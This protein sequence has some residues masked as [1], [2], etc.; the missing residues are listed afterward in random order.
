MQEETTREQRGPIVTRADI[1]A[2]LKALDLGPGSAA[3]V[4]SSLSAFG[5]VQGG[6]DAVI[7]ALLDTIGA[8][9]TLVMP[10]FTWGE[11]HA[12]KQVTFDT[13]H[14]VCETGRIPET[15]RQR[16]GVTR[17]LHVCHSVAACGP[18][19]DLAMGEGVSSF[20]RGSTFDG[21]L[22]LNAWVVMLGVSFQSCTALHAVEEFV[23]VGYREHRDFTESTVIL[24]DGA[25][26]SS[27][28]IEYLRVDSSANDFA[29]VE[30]LLEEAGVLRQTRI[31]AA[32]SSAVRIHDIFTVV[33]PRLEQDERFLSRSL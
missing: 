10:T 32:T 22:R 30:A 23:G 6:A 1:H 14:T 7:D 27:K 9:G 26:L 29:K 12:R 33:Q 31:G 13:R 21:L 3:M 19:T 4:H 28:A 8:T 17:S 20:G 2:G 16:Q 25:N 11:F 15:F 24:P 5:H 18:G